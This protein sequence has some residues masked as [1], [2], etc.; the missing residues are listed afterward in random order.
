LA[1]LI[2]LLI[3]GTIL[4]VPYE[5]GMRDEVPYNPLATVALSAEEVSKVSTNILQNLVFI[6]ISF[7]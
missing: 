3:L 4:E 7:F 5:N 2:L 1:L 6:L